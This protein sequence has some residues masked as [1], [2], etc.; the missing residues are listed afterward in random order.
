MPDFSGIPRGRLPAR[1]VIATSGA[2]HTP[3]PPRA[4]MP[5]SEHVEFRGHHWSANVPVALISAALT[6]LGMWLSRPPALPADD[7]LRR[8]VRDL[9][10]EQR[11]Q[12]QNHR[13]AMAA[14]SSSEMNTN[15]CRVDLAGLRE[16]VR[17]LTRLVDELKSRP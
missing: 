1:E 11:V 17:V 7:T 5:S 4:P 9:A 10:T 3:I 6:A 15:A 14:I 12:Q 2:P 8:D 13:D 16:D